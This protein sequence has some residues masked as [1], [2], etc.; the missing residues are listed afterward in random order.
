MEPLNQLPVLEAPAQGVPAL[1][2]TKTELA[3]ITSQLANGDGPLAVDTERAHGFR[4]APKAYLIQLRRSGAGTFLIDPTAF[5]DGAPRADLSDTAARLADAE[6]VIHAANQALPCLAELGFLPE[7]LF[8]TELAARLLNWPKVNLNAVTEITLGISLK[9]EYSAADWS[10]RPL[11]KAW[12]NY[13]ALDVE[14]LVELRERLSGEL[15]AAGKLEWATEEFS[16]LVRHA[17]DAPTAVNDPWRRTSGLHE[18]HTA[19]G[20]AVVREL[21]LA[22]DEIARSIDLAPG[23]VVRDQAIVALALRFDGS[24]AVVSKELL[25]AVRGFR[26]KVAFAHTAEWLAALDRAV[27]LPPKQLPRRQAPS[28]G[29]PNPRAW[30]KKS[31][32][33]HSRWLRVR[34]AVIARA[35]EIEVPVENLISPG[36]LRELLWESPAETDGPALAESLAVLGARPWQIAQVGPAILNAW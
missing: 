35:K 10:T 26:G 24:E 5:E 14:L 8:D 25:H 36:A 33:S 19:R 30:E 34:P 32:S 7:R 9:K 31:P 2:Q 16:Y 15:E 3:D 13:A 17:G 23:R 4:Y 28:E 6:W 18:L 12:L 1:T 11:P 20:I 21:W 29:I 27:A 22:R